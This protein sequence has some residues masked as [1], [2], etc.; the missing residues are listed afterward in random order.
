MYKWLT[1]FLLLLFPHNDHNLIYL[2]LSFVTHKPLQR[3]LHKITP[4]L[5]YISLDFITFLHS[6]CGPNTHCTCREEEENNMIEIVV[7]QKK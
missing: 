5:S 4:F 2:L 7:G 3:F 1:M 6:Q